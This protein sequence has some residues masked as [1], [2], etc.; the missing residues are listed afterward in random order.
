[1]D[2]EAAVRAIGNPKALNVIMLGAAFAAGALPFLTEE[3]VIAAIRAHVKPK[4]CA[5]NERA[6]RYAREVFS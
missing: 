6:L 3:D 4:Y 5:L 2:G 1:V